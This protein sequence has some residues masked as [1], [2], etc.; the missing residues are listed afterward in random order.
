VKEVGGGNDEKKE[1]EN[2]QVEDLFLT[3]DHVRSG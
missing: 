3:A 2:A 1:E